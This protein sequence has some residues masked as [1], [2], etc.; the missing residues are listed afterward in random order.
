M[1]VN[2]QDL[3]K[4]EREILRI[5][6]NLGNATAAEVQE[7]LPDAPGY[8]TV[9]K[10]LSILETKGHI[11]HSEKNRRYVYSPTQSKQSTRTTALKDLMGSL[12]EN[13]AE[14]V[15]STLMDVSAEKMSESDLERLAAIIERH[16]KERS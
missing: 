8:S 12:F 10:I 9:R 14:A 4:R 11:T 5:V 13:S 6:L 7:R 2:I 1:T 16:R 3:A 15:V